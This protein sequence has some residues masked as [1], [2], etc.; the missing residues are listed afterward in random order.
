MAGILTAV[1]LFFGGR[2]REV[3]AADHEPRHRV[4]DTLECS[5]AVVSSL[6]VARATTRRLVCSDR[7]R[8][9]VAV[10]PPWRAAALQRRS[11][12][13]GLATRQHIAS[14]RFSVPCKKSSETHNRVCLC[15]DE[16]RPATA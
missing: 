13:S 15:R 11:D 10:A 12:S 3:G 8:L 5:S 4:A 6:A 16:L 2:I 9:S 7:W 1:V 14:L